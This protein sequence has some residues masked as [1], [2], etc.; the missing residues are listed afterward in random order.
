MNVWDQ[1]KGIS[2]NYEIRSII[3]REQEESY[4]EPPEE[5]PKHELQR[6][7]ISHTISSDKFWRMF[8]NSS[9]DVK[10]YRDKTVTVELNIKSGHLEKEKAGPYGLRNQLQSL[11]RQRL[12]EKAED[13]VVHVMTP[14]RP[15]GFAFNNDV[16]ADTILQAAKK[17]AEPALDVKIAEWHF[18]VEDFKAKDP[19]PGTW[20][21]PVDRSEG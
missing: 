18:K 16:E 11:L 9:A 13:L 6:L 12:L 4:P 15:Q 3:I 2:N 14:G 20:P 17:L 8:C 10:A 7:N 21:P 5:L 19:A 1:F